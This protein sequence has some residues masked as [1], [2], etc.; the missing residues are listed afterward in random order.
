MFQGDENLDQTLQ[1]FKVANQT[2][3]LTSQLI[4]RV[5]S[6]RCSASYM[7]PSTVCLAAVDQRVV[8]LISNNRVTVGRRVF[9]Y[10]VSAETS[11]EPVV[12]YVTGVRVTG[13]DTSAWVQGL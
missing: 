1:V 2:S 13:A 5:F 4:L 10:R 3:L 11:L 8:D 7:V 9:G 12:C 6:E